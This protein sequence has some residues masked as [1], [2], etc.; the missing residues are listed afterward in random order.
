MSTPQ[1]NS[2]TEQ[3]NALIQIGE[4]LSGAALGLDALF[5]RIVPEVSRLLNA[6]RTTLFLVDR[7]RNEIWSK[8]AQGSENKEIRLTLGSG[9]AGWV[10]KNTQALTST[11]PYND[12][13]F[14]AKFDEYSGFKTQNLIAVPVL[15]KAGNAVAVLQVL[16][17]QECSEQALGLLQAIAAQTHYIIENAKLAE[18][19][20]ERNKDLEKARKQA[21]KRRDELDLLFNFEKAINSVNNLDHLLNTIIEQTCSHLRSDAG[22]ILLLEE[23][24]GQLYF[25]ET[26]SDKDN[27][28]KQLKIDLGQGLVGWVAKNAKP[29]IVNNPQDDPR[30]DA[31]LANELAYPVEAAIAVPLFWDNQVIGAVEV[32]NPKETMPGKDYY[33]LEDGRLLT[34]IAG[35]IARTVSVAIN[36]QRQF[37]TQRLVAVGHMLAG[38]AHDLRNPMTVISAFAQVLRQEENSEKRMEMS[39][40]IL[41]Q[42]DEMTSM[43]GDLLSYAQGKHQVSKVLF[44]LEDRG[45]EIRESL[46]VQCR[47]REISLQVET[48]GESAVC[49]LSKTKRIIYNLARNAIEVL[50]H[51]ESLTISLSTQNNS[52]HIMVQDNGPGIPED[53][54]EKMFLPFI[55]AG[56]EH[57][58]G[59]GLAIVKRFV[60]DHNGEINVTS[61]LG[62]GTTF[63]VILPKS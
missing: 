49:D 19:L 52:L 54:Q 15:D 45:K 17:I 43:I 58:V 29:L 61:A 36:R 46:D 31:K 6:E 24:S 30:H 21:D 2:S 56:K 42:V 55:T 38:V 11:D 3:L 1:E 23:E 22:S 4:A 8:V 35:Q 18:K 59:L 63:E 53:V 47:P 14:N 33:S 51:G 32:M 37:D 9:I 13:R 39:T 48:R 40:S 41:Q 27:E 12:P 26:L 44:K 20:L 25:R 57:G 60:E 7:R 50:K 28:L 62:E 34:L 5:S 16:N 10:A